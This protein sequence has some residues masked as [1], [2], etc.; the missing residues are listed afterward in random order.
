MDLINSLKISFIKIN[1]F[2]SKNESRERKSEMFS[3]VIYELI[4]D[5]NTLYQELLLDNK[6]NLV[7][8]HIFMKFE[9]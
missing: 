9:K 1:E 7:I 5:I 4:N 8:Y 3:N 2:I 6:N